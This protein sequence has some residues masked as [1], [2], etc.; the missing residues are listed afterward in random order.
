MIHNRKVRNEAK[1]A[2][3]IQKART[4]LEQMT[5]GT[6]DCWEGYRRV[7]GIWLSSSGRADELRPLFQIPNIHPDGC[8]DINDSVKISRAALALRESKLT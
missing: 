8:L 7:Y 4:V 3:W 2:D 1:R 5:D 6:L